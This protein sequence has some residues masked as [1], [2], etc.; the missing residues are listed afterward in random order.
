MRVLVTGGAGYIGSHTLVPLLRAGHEV[1]VYDNYATS[2][3]EALARVRQLANRDLAVVEGD[4]R[5][6]ALLDRTF[7]SFRPDAVIHF[8]GL[9]AVGE[10]HSQPLEYY[11][12]NIAGSITLLQ[13]MAQ[14][15]CTQIVFSSSATVY[16]EPDYLPYD[17]HH[18]LRPQS[19]YGRSK[20]MIET[21]IR[22]W[23]SANAGARAILLRY[24]NPVGA[25]PSGRIGED[26]LGT[27]NNLMPYIAQVAIGRREALLVHGDDYDTRDGTGERDYIHV[28]DLARAHLA[29]LDSLDRIDGCE[30]IN[31]GTGQSATVL[32]MV[33]AFERASGRS[34]PYRI[35]PRRPGD[36]A[37][38]C[39]DVAKARAL[40]GWQAEL[41]LDAMCSATWQWQSRNPTGYAPEVERD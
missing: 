39:A 23:T 34:V 14:N 26:P 22:D 38:M 19:P 13:C 3:P 28:E 24:F 11:A 7:A 18:P 15:G 2:S 33:A 37:R 31:V 1:L 29:A 20:L 9:K 4:I 30:A 5:D 27:P 35:G 41:G 40:M 36:V 6:L 32:E 17:E 10:S 12:Q 16:G 25:H 21:I 8:A